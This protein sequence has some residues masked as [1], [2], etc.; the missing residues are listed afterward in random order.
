MIKKIVL[1]AMSV[2]SRGLSNKTIDLQTKQLR[3]L[4]CF[5]YGDISPCPFLG[6]SKK[7]NYQYCTKCGCGDKKASWLLKDGKEYSKLDYPVLNCPAKM[8]GFTNY[9]P[10]YVLPETRQRKDQIENFDPENLKLIQVTI[11]GNAE[12]EKIIDDL[13]KILKNS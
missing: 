8:P 3:A 10:N 9:D 5:G 13:N 12:N 6:Q 4:S 7:T 11:N 1:F 2:A